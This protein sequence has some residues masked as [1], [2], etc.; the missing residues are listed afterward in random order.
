MKH[1]LLLISILCLSGC[2]SVPKGVTPKPDVAPVQQSVGK[3]Q[4][5]TTKT[6]EYVGKTKESQDQAIDS[7][8]KATESLEKY[9]GTDGAVASAKSSLVDATNQLE[10]ARQYNQWADT[11]LANAW[12]YEGDAKQQITVLSGQIDTAHANETVAV[13]AVEKWKPIIDQVNS[14]WG[15][16]AFAYGFKRLASHLLILS[17]VL[18]ALGVVV[19]FVF[20]AA[21]PVVVALFRKVSS[22]IG[23]LVSLVTGLFRKK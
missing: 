1:Q 23:S 13:T 16:G 19:F 5:S 2:M 6:R 11:E 9:T 18:G 17:L 15:L 8:R 7:V 22:M 21:I 12:K 10:S 20:P 14:W 3:L 4:A